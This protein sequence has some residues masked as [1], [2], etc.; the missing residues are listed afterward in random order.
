[1][2]GFKVPN[3][4]LKSHLKHSPLIV[5]LFLLSRQKNHV[6]DFTFSQIAA[7]L[8]ISQKTV[9]NSVQK[10]IV[11]GLISKENKTRNGRVVATQFK[12][13][14][15]PNESWVWVETKL[16]DL[17]LTSS[18]LNVYL[19][20]KCRANQDGRAWPAISTIHKDTGLAKETVR[21]AIR[22]LMAASLLQRQ[23]KK[24][25]CNRFGHN[26]YKSL[27]CMQREAI[28]IVLRKKKAST[29]KIRC[30]LIKK[31][32]NS[33]IASYHCVNGNSM[34]LFKILRC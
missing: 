4:I 6:A 17:D 13:A 34:P 16:F 32:Y 24:K 25:V 9:H 14:T 18:E 2:R 12:L 26:E 20:I 10:L 22:G 21:K 7:A 31:I 8:N 29:R 15:L 33:S 19:Y 27:T 1:M 5:Y 3:S 30:R 11:S 23:H 28:L